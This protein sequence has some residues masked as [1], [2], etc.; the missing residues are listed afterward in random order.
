MLVR[1]HH[2]WICVTLLIWCFSVHHLRW[3]HSLGWYWWA[4]MSENHH[5]AK[6]HKGHIFWNPAFVTLIFNLHYSYIVDLKQE[7]TK[8]AQCMP[9][10]LKNNKISA[11]NTGKELL[12]Y[13]KLIFK[14]LM[15]WTEPHTITKI[16]SRRVGSSS[17]FLNV[18]SPFVTLP[19]MA[20][21][22]S[23]NTT[24]ASLCQ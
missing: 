23:L 13:I 20:Y 17:S 21:W 3:L 6:V 1:L 7:E 5:W 9:N 4:W 24:V 16:P 12:R 11:D 14:K 19:K 8:E 18:S 10:G 2:M 15:D 22:S